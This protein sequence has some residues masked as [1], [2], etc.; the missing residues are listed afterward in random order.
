MHGARSMYSYETR[1]TTCF[2]INIL[3]VAS[4][5]IDSSTR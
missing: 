2:A 4:V 5:R 1:E 3:A